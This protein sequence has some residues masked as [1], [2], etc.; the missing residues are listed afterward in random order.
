METVW[1][2][3]ALDQRLGALTGGAIVLWTIGTA[4]AASITT[5]AIADA[6]VAERQTRAQ[7]IAARLDRTFEEVFRQLDRV[8]AASSSSPG[9]VVHAVQALTAAEAVIRVA[10]DGTVLWTRNATDGQEC[11]PVI[12]AL[13][14]RFAGRHISATGRL[15][16]TRGARVFLIV[17]A[18]ESDPA[19]GVL[20]A[21]LDTDR[22]P[23]REVI[24]S[25][26]S[27]PYRV[28]LLDAEGVEVS[29][30]RTARYSGEDGAL[31]T[32]DFLFAQ[33]PV[34]NGAWRLQLSQ[35]RE[36]ALAP[37]FRLRRVLVGSSL[38]LIPF[39][40]LVAWGAARSIRQPV[41]AMTVAAE[42]LARG[43][44]S[45]A[46]PAA[47]EDE[48]GRLA[49]ALEQ[50]RKTLEADERRSRL[51]KRVMS[52]QEEERRRI[53]RELHDETTQQ[54]TVLAMQL[55]L[56]MPH[57]AHTREL[58]ERSRALVATMVDDI[59]RVI[60]DLR[61][62]MLDDLGLLPAVRAFAEKRLVPAGVD[63]NCEFP[64]SIPPL[65]PELTTALYRVAQEAVNNVAR[66]AHASAVLIACTITD[67]HLTLEIEDDGAGFE[68]A[69]VAQPRETGEGL[70]LL[71]M[72][73]RL[74]LVGGE[75]E[76]ESE[77]GRGTRV[78]ASAPLPVH[79]ATRS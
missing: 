22:G 58:L 28:R 3:R 77:P 75:L 16:T 45:A 43:E 7:A 68:P 8:A 54:L 23:I 48:I 10:P 52:A 64:I 4:I 2:R 60:Y 9:A 13:P 37:V 33:T 30:S 40:L 35:P 59:H 46:M 20:A 62:S 24:G 26:A 78:I 57:D 6:I 31:R 73:E 41:V 65:S 34:A 67:S 19:S 39:A 18:R 29:A 17:P 69:R 15:D 79:G 12:R 27:E 74:T 44:Y 47:G 49:A 61:P 66:H 53:A 14:A 32:A 72:R 50:L 76:I 38:L 71:G 36:E 70:G 51:L 25:Y 63:V 11:T 5:D 42:Q 56:A 1:W 55:G 21:M